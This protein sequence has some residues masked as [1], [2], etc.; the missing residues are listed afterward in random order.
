MEGNE[1]K[2]TCTIMGI[3]PSVGNAQCGVPSSQD[4]ARSFSTTSAGGK[5]HT[6]R[7]FLSATAAAGFSLTIVPRHVLGGP[8]QVP[9]SERV[10]VAGIGAG[11]MGGG[12]IATVHRLGANIVALCDVDEVRAAGSVHP[13]PKARREQALPVNA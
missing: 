3:Q 9:P 5:K 11:G 8:G 12:D 1:T 6:R 7:S 13:L 10:N 4:R 2:R